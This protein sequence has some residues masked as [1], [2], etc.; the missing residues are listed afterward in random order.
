MGAMQQLSGFVDDT[1]QLLIEKLDGFAS[2][3][4]GSCNLG[5]WLHYFAFDVRVDVQLPCHELP[6]ID[7]NV[8]RFVGSR[9]NG[10]F[11]KIRLP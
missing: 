4:G 7:T 11:S 5:D 8:T 6:S 3:P 9:R 1:E 2:R 10:I